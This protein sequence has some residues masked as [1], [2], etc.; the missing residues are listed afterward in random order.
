MSLARLKI[1]GSSKGSRQLGRSPTV[2]LARRPQRSDTLRPV[3]YW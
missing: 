3:A 2:V 1:L